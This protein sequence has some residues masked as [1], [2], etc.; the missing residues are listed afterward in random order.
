[1][2]FEVRLSNCCSLQCVRVAQ[3]Y[4]EHIVPV[5][6]LAEYEGLLVAIIIVGFQICD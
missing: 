1:M 3:S 4:R 6:A 2:V 5:G